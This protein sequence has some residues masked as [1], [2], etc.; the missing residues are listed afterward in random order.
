MNP[1]K[2]NLFIVDG[3]KPYDENFILSFALEKIH[4]IRKACNYTFELPMPVAIECH[5]VEGKQTVNKLFG[6]TKVVTKVHYAY[7]LIFGKELTEAEM[8][9]WRMFKMGWRSA[10]WPRY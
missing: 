5:R 8:N 6:G 3:Y 7:N 1:T 9:M 4:E 10:R 2:L